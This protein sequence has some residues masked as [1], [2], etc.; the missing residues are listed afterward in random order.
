LASTHRIG[1]RAVPARG[2]NAQV[3]VD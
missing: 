1:L 3:N 2:S